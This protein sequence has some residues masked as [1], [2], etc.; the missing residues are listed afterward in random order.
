ML[1]L[2][3]R[4]LLLRKLV[5]TLVQLLLLMMK[6]GRL[7]LGMVLLPLRLCNLEGKLI[8]IG[9]DT[10]L[11]IDCELSVRPPDQIIVRQVF[12]IIILATAAAYRCCCGCISATARVLAVIP[13]GSWC[14]DVLLLRLLEMMVVATVGMCRLML[15]I[16]CCGGC[17]RIMIN[18]AVHFF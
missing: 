14:R 12:W 8:F 1:L 6:H 16:G 13:G 3:F 4:L 2:L 11:V 15:A 7:L 5:I 18:V 9:V 10:W 17:S